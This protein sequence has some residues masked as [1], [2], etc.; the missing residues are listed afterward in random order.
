MR[1]RENQTEQRQIVDRE[2]QGTHCR[3]KVPIRDTG[4]RGDRDDGAPAKFW[5]E[6]AIANDEDDQAAAAR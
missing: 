6:D 1:G 2:A 3:V 5:Q 4:H